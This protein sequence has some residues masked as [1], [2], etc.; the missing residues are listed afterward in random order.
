MVF[1][2]IDIGTTNAK[3]IAL[4]SKGTVLSRV[5][6]SNPVGFVDVFCY[7]D[8]ADMMDRFRFVW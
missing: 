4:D 5:T 3:G 1:C 8:F 6:L 2:G 7:K